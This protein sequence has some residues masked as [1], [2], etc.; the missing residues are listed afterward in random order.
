M[1]LVF[2]ESKPRLW[3]LALMMNSSVARR[4]PVP[5]CRPCPPH[6]RAPRGRGRQSPAS[7]GGGGASWPQG[8]R[9]AAGGDPGGEV[10]RFVWG[11]QGGLQHQGAIPPSSERASSRGQGL[12]SPGRPAPRRRR[13]E[14]DR[15]PGAPPARSPGNFLGPN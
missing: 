2:V 7:L 12:H 8:A 6:R 13:L 1:I 14:L 11:S 15:G 3:S 5:G 9:A 4:R 10:T